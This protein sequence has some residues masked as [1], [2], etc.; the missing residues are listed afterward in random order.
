MFAGYSWKQLEGEVFEGRVRL[1]STLT[2][3][4]EAVFSA[5]WIGVS[6]PDI[7][8]RVAYANTEPLLERYLEASFFEHP[9]LLHCFGAGEFQ[10]NGH[11]LIYAILAR[12]DERL[13]DVLA[14]G[15]LSTSEAL[16]LGRQIAAAL[17]Y[18]HHQNL[19]Y[20]TLD[21]AT[22]AWSRSEAAA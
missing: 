15:P 1:G 18:L 8:V 16:R 17:A 21:P 12:S 20:C 14:N 7:V 19:V 6:A 13:S 2:A 4:R 11:R 9:N 5:E 10:R 22:G 3:D